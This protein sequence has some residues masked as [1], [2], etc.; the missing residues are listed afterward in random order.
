M[1]GQQLAWV[2]LASCG[3]DVV[4][5]AVVLCWVTAGKHDAPSE[6]SR[7]PSSHGGGGGGGGTDPTKAF[8]TNTVALF[9]SSTASAD[10]SHAAVSGPAPGPGAE[11][12]PPLAALR[13]R[14]P[15][16][17]VF[18]RGRSSSTSKPRSM[19]PLPHTLSH[20]D[21]ELDLVRAGQS[22]MHSVDS[23]TATDRE[24]K[25]PTDVDAEDFIMTVPVAV[26]MPMPMLV[27]VPPISPISPVSPV[28][29]PTSAHHASAPLLRA[30][31]GSSSTFVR[32]NTSGSASESLSVHSTNAGA[33]PPAMSSSP[34]LSAR[35]Q[36]PHSHS[37]SHLQ[38]QPQHQAQGQ[39]PARGMQI[40]ITRETD[41]VTDFVDPVRLSPPAS[42]EKV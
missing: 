35:F 23:H 42:D 2:C 34:S 19:H 29:S 31:S 37:H 30:G 5:N 39:G 32:S 36:F 18:T 8:S 41:V 20:A 22:D 7:D 4:V 11:R 9:Y 6:H 40:V 26:A 13:S 1:H 16:V 25:H 33:G 12:Q 38:P 17:N 28:L 14:F 24:S 3:T 21:V 27:P 10:Y 15:N